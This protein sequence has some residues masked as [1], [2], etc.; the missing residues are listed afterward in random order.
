MFLTRKDHFFSQCFCFS[1]RAVFIHKHP[2]IRLYSEHVVKNRSLL[3]K[4]AINTRVLE[5]LFSKLAIG[6]FPTFSIRARRS[7]FS[8]HTKKTDR[9]PTSLT[10]C[11]RNTCCYDALCATKN[12]E[13]NKK[14][15]DSSLLMF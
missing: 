14:S 11:L 12:G 4:D 2:L 5:V 9:S 3:S 1:N 15:S 13:K 7:F 8:P 10:W 6:F